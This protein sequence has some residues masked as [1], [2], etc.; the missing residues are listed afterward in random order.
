MWLKFH[1]WRPTQIH[2]D[3]TSHES[4]PGRGWNRKAEAGLNVCA[5]DWSARSIARAS[6][7][8]ED[9]NQRCKVGNQSQS[10]VV[11]TRK[12]QSIRI[13]GFLVTNPGISG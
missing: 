9:C 13:D 4:R 2:K 3:N 8:L 1:T 5:E 6:D 12:H 10:I 7:L 11:G